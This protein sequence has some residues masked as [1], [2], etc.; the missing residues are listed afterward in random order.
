MAASPSTLD[1]G[2]QVI[3]AAGSPQTVTVRNSGNVANTPNAQ[4]SGV[5]A[6]DYAI[7]TNGCGRSLAAGASCTLTVSFAPTAS[8][9]RAATLAVT[10]TGGSS[11]SVRLSGTGRLNPVLAVSPAVIMPG[12]VATITG[13]NFPAGA[14]VTLAWDVGGAAASTVA[15]GGGAFSVAAV[16]PSGLGSGTRRLVVTAPADAAAATASLLVQPPA[17]GA[18]GPRL[19]QLAG[20]VQLAVRFSSP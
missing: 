16:V 12:Q 18:V 9:G 8:G 19:R 4:L 2:E 17:P 13:T 14:A 20:E 7:A 3:G 10:G 5:A 1:F 15:D 11:A 6:A